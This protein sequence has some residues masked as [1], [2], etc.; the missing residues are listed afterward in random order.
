MYTKKE[1]LKII[2][3]SS[4]EFLLFFTFSIAL[5]NSESLSATGSFQVVSPYIGII[6]SSEYTKNITFSDNCYAG[7]AC[8]ASNNGGYY[9][10]TFISNILGNIT[11]SSTD[12]IGDTYNI[13]KNFFRMNVT[14]SPQY[15]S[16]NYINSQTFAS[17]I[18][19]NLLTNNTVLLSNFWVAIP[20]SAPP[21]DNDY[22]AKI[23]I[24]V[25]PS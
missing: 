20:S 11:Y 18:N 5:V 4:I 15:P 3:L 17:L 22:I 13:S 7:D 8:P 19:A 16:T 21:S 24:T 6:L 9:N 23:S 25:T 14:K 1:N 10:V 12:F 2:I